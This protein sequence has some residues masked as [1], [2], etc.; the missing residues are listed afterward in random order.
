PPAFLL[1]EVLRNLAQL[2]TWPAPNHHQAVP[3]ESVVALGV[4]AAEAGRTM[5]TSK[6]AAHYTVKANTVYPFWT[7]KQT[8][9]EHR[10]RRPAGLSKCTGQKRLLC[11]LI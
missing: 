1:W 10:S 8:V 7:L 9:S 2:P 6:L 4:E 3:E 5:T 11:L